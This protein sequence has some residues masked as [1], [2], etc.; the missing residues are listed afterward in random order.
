[1]PTKALVPMMATLLDTHVE[2]L[3][4]GFSFV[5]EHG[6]GGGLCSSMPRAGSK[7]PNISV[8]IHPDKKRHSP[9]LSAKKKCPT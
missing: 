8:P 5:E 1:M 3:P 6:I 2:N 9:R 4:K 7:V